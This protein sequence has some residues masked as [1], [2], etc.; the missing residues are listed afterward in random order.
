[1]LQYSSLFSHSLYRLLAFNGSFDLSTESRANLQALM[2]DLLFDEQRDV[3]TAA[4]A[5]LTAIL[6]VLTDSHETLF[7]R[8]YESISSREQKSIRKG[9]WQALGFNR[10]RTIYISSQKEKRRWWRRDYFNKKDSRSDL[11]TLSYL[12]PIGEIQSA[13][14]DATSEEKLIDH[15][16]R[17]HSHLP[18]TLQ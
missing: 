7:V 1:M 6:R 9:K 3:S 5:S 15:S 16:P 18:Q 11:I 10:K 2:L 12:H 4:K 17:P 8:N 14:G 13:D